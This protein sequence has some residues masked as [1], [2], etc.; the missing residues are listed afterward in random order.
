MTLLTM[1]T[2]SKT[3]GSLTP[4]YVTNEMFPPGIGKTFAARLRFRQTQ[5]VIRFKEDDQ[6][7]GCCP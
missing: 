2:L 7:D 3:S 5:P 6:M 4:A 1:V